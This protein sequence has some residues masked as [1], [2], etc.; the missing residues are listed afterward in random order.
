LTQAFPLQWPDGWPRT[1]DAARKSRSPFYV[2]PDKARKDLLHELRLLKAGNVV[3]STNIPIRQ[4]GHPF[5]AK[6]I[7]SDPGVAVYFTL[8]GRQLAM[9]RDVFMR[10]EDNMRS[11]TLAIA[12]IRAIERHGGQYMME[13]AFSG[14]MA[15]PSPRSCWD[16]LG[17]DPRPNQPWSEEAINNAY[18]SRAKDCHPDMGGST[19]AMA[20]LSQARDEALKAAGA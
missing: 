7:I 19:S 2:S 4:D 18:R 9:A 20:E 11:L 10:I 13:M 5:A 15:L 16:V 17:L 12:G 1:A 8:N 6:R 14:F 3:L